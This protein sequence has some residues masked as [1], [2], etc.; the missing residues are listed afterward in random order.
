ME[1]VRFVECNVKGVRNGFA[2]SSNSPLLDLPPELLELIASHVD[3]HDLLRWRLGC[4]ALAQTASRAFASA[5]FRNLTFI[6]ADGLSMMMLVNITKHKYLTQCLQRICIS[7]AKPVVC[8]SSDRYGPPGQSRK[9]R[10]DNRM[11]SKVFQDMVEANKSFTIDSQRGS[12][13]VS[14]AQ[15]KQCGIT[16]SISSTGLEFGAYNQPKN[17][18]RLV[19]CGGKRSLC[20]R[21]DLEQAYEAIYSAIILSQYPIGHLQLGSEDYPVPLPAFRMTPINTSF[22][23]LHTLELTL[24]PQY[25]GWSHLRRDRPAPTLEQ[26]NINILSLLHLFLFAEDTTTLFLEIGPE[27]AGFHS[28]IFVALATTYGLGEDAILMLPKL[29]KLHL[30]GHRIRHRDL[31]DF[32]NQRK[33]SLREITLRDVHDMGLDVPDLADEIGEMLVHHGTDWRVATQRC[34]NGDGWMPQWAIDAIA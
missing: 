14:L 5:F 7:L 31:T 25:G 12:L 20:S 9:E 1:S 33:A 2:M 19:Y 24:A 17:Y 11:R 8:Y 6:L 3:S 30:G 18:H 21:T 32:I 13:A 16:P 29:E 26:L 22:S 15:L 4:N 10:A 23:E 28:N 27:D 34:Y